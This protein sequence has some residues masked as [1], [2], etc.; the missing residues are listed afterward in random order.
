MLRPHLDASAEN[1]QKLGTLL[2]D[3]L[4]RVDKDD[5]LLLLL[6]EDNGTSGLTGPETGNGHFT[7]LCRNNL[8]SNKEGAAAGAG[9]LLG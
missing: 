4:A 6:I 1:K 7:A 3:G 5:Q 2:L 9:V 8:D